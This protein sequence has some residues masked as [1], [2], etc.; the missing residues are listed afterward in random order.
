MFERMK[1][2]QSVGRMGAIMGLAL[3]TAAC[4]TVDRLQDVGKAPEL[5]PITDPQQVAGYQPVSL[6]M[7]NPDVVEYE[8]NS[9]WRSGARA[10]FRDQRA[11]RVG[12]ILTVVIEIEDEARRTA[13]E[14]V[15]INKS[16]VEIPDDLIADLI[17]PFDFV[18][19][20]IIDGV[21][22]QMK[23][24]LN[25]RT[26]PGGHLLLTGILE[27]REAEFCERFSFE[28]YEIVERVQLKEWIGFL[29]INRS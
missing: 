10:F 8:P 24:H 20:N 12:D 2:Y 7:P 29:L 4:N 23:Q 6:P 17:E 22:V 16:V 14:N 15:A 3:M 25:Q 1:R 26:L 19:A 13:R 21:L 18:I 28:D 27:E 9:L 11:K 5:A